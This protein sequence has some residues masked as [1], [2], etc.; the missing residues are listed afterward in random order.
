MAKAQT[1]VYDTLYDNGIEVYFPNQ[2]RTNVEN[3]IVVITS[4]GQYRG[5]GSSTLGSE[6]IHLILHVP[7]D[8]Y[9]KLFELEKEVKRAMKH[10]KWVTP[11]G[12]Q[13]AP[14]NDDSKESYSLSIEYVVFKS[15]K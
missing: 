3:P 15:L 7:Q 14:Y 4:L 12:M 1:A 13:T 10:L 8:D 6:F 9:L 5:L 2:H 11:T